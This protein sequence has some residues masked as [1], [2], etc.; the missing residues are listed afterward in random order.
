VKSS[1]YYFVEGEIQR[2]RPLASVALAV[3]VTLPSL[4]QTITGSVSVVAYL[5]RLALALAV[6]VVLLWVATG[7]FL[8]YARVQ[9]R[10]KGANEGEPGAKTGR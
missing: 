4:W 3:L 10:A 8:H 1:D 2:R 6:S 7:V 9:A 5:T